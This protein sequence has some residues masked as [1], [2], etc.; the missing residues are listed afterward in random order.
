MAASM[1]FS[2]QTKKSLSALGLT[3]VEIDPQLA[4]IDVDGG[5]IELDLFKAEKLEKVVFCTINMQATGVVE[6]TAM[7]WPDDEHNLPLLW[8]NLTI[9]PEVMNVPVFDFAP[10]MDIVV[11]PD[12]A[13]RY[14]AGLSDLRE[15][16]FEQLGDT[17]IDKAVNLPSLSVY[18]LSPYRLIANI[19]S[20]GVEK[21]PPIAAAYIDAYISLVQ[22]ATAL[23][24]GPEKQFYL[25]KKAETRKLMKANDPGYH[26]MTDVFGEERT[27]AV[28]D[29]VF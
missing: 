20:A 29:I 23:E 22:G 14:T 16:A 25:K 5:T 12:Y 7:A 6:S 13:R 17:V 10:M 19:T 11:W 18:A 1:D 2:G 28:F 21:T 27:H 4:R 9:V 15:N 24:D 8:C 26:F 3:A